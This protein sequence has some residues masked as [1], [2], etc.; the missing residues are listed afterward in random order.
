MVLLI[1]LLLE[2]ETEHSNEN[3]LKP[4]SQSK[5]RSLINKDILFIKNTEVFKYTYNY[6]VSN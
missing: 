1:Q 4:R 2:G 5:L 3:I 6:L